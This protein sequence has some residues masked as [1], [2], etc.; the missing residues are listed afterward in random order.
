MGFGLVTE[1]NDPATPPIITG[2]ESLGIF[3]GDQSGVNITDS[4]VM[5][6][7]GGKVGI[8]TVSP[9]TELHVVGDI[10]YTGTLTDISDRRLKTD[11][12]P[13]GAEDMIARL[14]AVDTYTFRMKGDESGRVEYGV[15]AQELEEI[16]PELVN[17]ADDEMGTK[18]VNYTG[19]IAPMIEATKAL[20]TENDALKAELD[21]VKAQQKLVLATLETMQ[22]DMNG[23]KVHTGYGIEKG[24]AL[25]LLILL[26][27][28]GGMAGTLLVQ[29]QKQGNIG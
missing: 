10:Q 3:M 21:A 15:M 20:K 9:N 14:S 2:D 11:I 24:N 26:L 13:L 16:F 4:Q 18:S 12:T 1:A 6:V 28:L 5:S 27:S 17:T 7:M 19:L 23:M 29:R 25:A 8:G 22:S